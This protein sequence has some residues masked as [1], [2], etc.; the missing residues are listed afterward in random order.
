MEC[1]YLREAEQTELFRSLLHT[2]ERFTVPE[3]IP[4]LCTRQGMLL[5]I[6][7]YIPSIFSLRF[8]LH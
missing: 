5:H 2:D 7:V 4:S 6:S 8:S 3:T 1:D